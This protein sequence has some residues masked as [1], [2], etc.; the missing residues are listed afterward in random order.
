VPPPAQVTQGVRGRLHRHRS[1]RRY[2]PNFRLAHRL[3]DQIARILELN[4]L[5]I[6]TSEAVETARESL[7]IGTPA[8][9]ANDVT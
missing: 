8:T 3:F 1:H 6:I 2:H 9:S 4:G 5:H 7:I